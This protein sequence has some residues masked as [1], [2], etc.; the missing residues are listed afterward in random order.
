MR[1][2][3]PVFIVGYIRSGTTLVAAILDRHSGIAVPPETHFYERFWPKDDARMSRS[4]PEMVDEYWRSLD[5]AGL[6]PGLDHAKLIAAKRGGA[7]AW[8]DVLRAV[9]STY[10]ESK[11]KQSFAEKTPFHL[12]HVSRILRDFPDAKVVFVTRDG[13]DAL[14]SVNQVWPFQKSVEVH[15][16]HWRRAMEIMFAHERA[17][18]GRI[19]RVSYEA[20]VRSPELET[21]RL[22]AFCGVDFEATQLDHRIPTE[23][24]APH[25]LEWKK[26]IFRPIEM[27]NR[28][29][30]RTMFSAADQRLLNEIV[31]PCNRALG[32]AADD[33]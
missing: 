30:W 2:S 24:A 27:I 16:W 19:F 14:A 13:R 33:G 20:L 21:Q 3:Q 6:C 5:G 28:Q 29:R 1:Q 9:L 11:G 18:G 17:F 15:A 32:L 12:Y 26:N 23:V 10:A 31:A 25:E 7:P 22:C 4:W 8:A